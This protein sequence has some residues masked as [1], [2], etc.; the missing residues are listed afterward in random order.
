MFCIAIIVYF[1]KWSLKKGPFEDFPVWKLKK[2]AGHL[3]WSDEWNGHL[4]NFR[5]LN[6]AVAMH[7]V[8]GNVDF[9]RIELSE[10]HNTL[11]SPSLSV[12]A[13]SDWLA[14]DIGKWRRFK[15]WLKLKLRHIQLHHH[16][17]NHS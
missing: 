16:D 12:S 13:G 14:R 8:M 17:T 2:D 15:L 3:A 7:D 10:V 5:S 1:I 9:P 6:E 4:I 11:W